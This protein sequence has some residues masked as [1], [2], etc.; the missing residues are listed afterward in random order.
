MITQ[1]QTVGVQPHWFSL[2]GLCFRRQK[3]WKPEG[4]PS[5]QNVETLRCHVLTYWDSEKNP[6]PPKNT[7]RPLD[8]P[9]TE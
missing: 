1:K 8:L 9:P 5:L 7:F 2:S 4:L 3:W 6:R